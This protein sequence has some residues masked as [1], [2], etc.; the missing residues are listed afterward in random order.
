MIQLIERIES[1]VLQQGES[2]T[3]DDIAGLEFAKQN[4]EEIV[5]WPIK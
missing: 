4:I 1:E 5:V 2:V 3:F